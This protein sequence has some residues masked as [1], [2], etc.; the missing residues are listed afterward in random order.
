MRN[1]NNTLG[2]VAQVEATSSYSVDR[3][4]NGSKRYQGS[5]GIPALRTKSSSNQV[6]HASTEYWQDAVA[7]QQVVISIAE[8]KLVS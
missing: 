8:G 5:P 1:G 6:V 2:L 3:F 7:V 4:R